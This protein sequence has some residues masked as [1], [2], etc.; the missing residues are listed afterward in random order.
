MK[1]RKRLAQLF[2]KHQYTVEKWHWCH[3][4]VGAD[5]AFIE[6]FE[7]CPKCGKRKYFWVER[8]SAL[9]KALLAQ[10]E[11]N[12]AEDRRVKAVLNAAH[13]ER[14]HME[15]NLKAAWEDGQ[16]GANK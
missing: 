16:K 4:P 7:V 9:E 6:G 11:F 13:P 8:G 3:G 14:A 5:P 15:A 12:A 1:I 2:C 10:E